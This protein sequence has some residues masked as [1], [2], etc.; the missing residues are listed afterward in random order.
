M[1]YD[2]WKST[3]PVS[4]D[5]LPEPTCATCGDPSLALVCAECEADAVAASPCGMCS[6]PVNDRE[7]PRIGQ[8]PVCASCWLYSSGLS[9]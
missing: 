2:T 1:N 8:V 6:Q 4:L 7:P 3:E 5:D 9:E